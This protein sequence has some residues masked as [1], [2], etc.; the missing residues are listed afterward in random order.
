MTVSVGAVLKAHRKPFIAKLLPASCSPT[1]ITPAII[2]GSESVRYL[3]THQS[4][5]E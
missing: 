2:D 3:L 5:E 4:H 1:R